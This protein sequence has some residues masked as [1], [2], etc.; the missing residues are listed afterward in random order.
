MRTRTW[1]RV[2]CRSVP[3]CFRLWLPV[4]ISPRGLQTK[5]KAAQKKAAKLPQNATRKGRNGTKS[6]TKKDRE[7]AEKVGQKKSPKVRENPSKKRLRKFRKVYTKKMHP[8]R[9][10]KTPRNGCMKRKNGRKVRKSAHKKR[11]RRGAGVVVTW[12]RLLAGA[13]VCP[14]QSCSQLRAS[15]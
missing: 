11:P 13:C 12:W 2:W 15:I 8:G 6:H 9:P 10:H 4:V 3:P 1:A 5:Q 7:T 14:L